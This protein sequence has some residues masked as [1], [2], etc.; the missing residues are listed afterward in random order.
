MNRKVDPNPTSSKNVVRKTILR[1][2]E[3]L[4]NPKVNVIQQNRK[5]VSDFRNLRLDENIAPDN[6]DDVFKKPHLQ[7]TLKIAKKITETRNL[8]PKFRYKST[9]DHLTPKTKKVFK[10]EVIFIKLF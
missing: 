8:H 9:G 1:N 5:S 3:V 4:I 6:S 10:D 2:V 7:T